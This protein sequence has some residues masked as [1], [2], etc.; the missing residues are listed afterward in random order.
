MGTIFIW[1]GSG[2]AFSVGLLAGLCIIPF[3]MQ[4]KSKADETNE[5]SLELLK[6]RNEIDRQLLA[7]VEEIAAAMNPD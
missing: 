1:L 6:E 7:A 4:R 2:F 3:V 5:K